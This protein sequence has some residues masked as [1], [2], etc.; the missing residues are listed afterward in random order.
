MTILFY[1]RKS[2][3]PGGLGR[4]NCRITVNSEKIHLENTRIKADP[5]DWDPDKQKFNKN[6]ESAKTNNLRL[7][8]ITA[9]LNT[10][11]LDLESRGKR[12]TASEIKSIYLGNTKSYYKFSEIKDLFLAQ[13]LAVAKKKKVTGEGRWSMSTYDSYKDRLH[14]FSLYLEK[15]NL[16]GIFADEVK[17]GVINRFRSEKEQAVGRVYSGKL[18]QAVKTCLIWACDQDYLEQNPLEPVKIHIPNIVDTTHISNEELNLLEN[19]ELSVRLRNVIDCYLFSCYTGLSYIDIKIIGPSDVVEI[20]GRIC[21]KK[22]RQKSETPFFI[23][24]IAKARN[25]LDKYGGI[26]SFVLPV[27]SNKEM[28]MLLR[29]ATEKCG[30]QKYLW[31]HTGRK[32]FSDTLINE[33]NMTKT[34][35][36]AAMGQTNEKEL[37]AYVRVRDKRVLAEF[38]NI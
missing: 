5:K 22:P 28:N 35:A 30:I 31:Y 37:D 16:E 38:P 2:K 18:C 11:Y 1:L 19:T 14:Q 29:V 36:I 3:K 26:K 23:P 33:Y 7:D 32:K 12:A 6:S 10:I 9:K 17:K 4:I 13:V 24:L 34:A 21:L 15:N 25:L 20:D 8:A 27:K